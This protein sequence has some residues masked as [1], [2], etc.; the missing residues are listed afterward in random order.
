[1]N[2]HAK[3]LGPESGRTAWSDGLGSARPAHPLAPAHTFAPARPTSSRR[4]PRRRWGR[5]RS[6]GQSLVEFALVLIP[7]FFILLGIIQFGFIF[8]TYVTMTSATREAARS[9]TIYIYDPAQSKTQN[10]AARN[11]AI[12]ASLIG[13][14][15]YLPKTSP[16]FTT[17]STWT[18]SNGG[19]TFTNGDLTITYAV[20][21]TITD[22]DPR[23]GEQITVTA[24]FHQDLII[25]MIAIL[26]PRDANGRLGLSGQI[27]MVIN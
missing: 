22:S 4:G 11:E 10:D 8:N 18:S 21:A 3:G 23:T 5:E 24:N 12:K 2:T 6:G 1:M 13:A 26:L 27:T 14:M 19:L 7:L 20:P 16:Q 17:G 25:P 9:G 15:N